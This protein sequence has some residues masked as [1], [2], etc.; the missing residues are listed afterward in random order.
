MFLPLALG[1]VITSLGLCLLSISSSIALACAA[2]FPVGFGSAVFAIPTVTIVQSW[3]DDKTRA[4]ATGFAM[5]G[6]GLGN[7][8]FAFVLQRLID[9]QGWRSAL[10]YEAALTLVVTTFGS[11]LVYR[12]TA[13]GAAA[14]AE[15]TAASAEG[16]STASRATLVNSMSFSEVTR[17]NPFRSVVAFKFIF[18]L[19]YLVF[20]VHI[21]SY[22]QGKNFSSKFAALALAMIGGASILGRISLGYL[23]D[24]I[25]IV[26]NL[27]ISV[28]VLIVCVLLW[29]HMSSSTAILF[30]C[31]AYGFFAGAF[32]SLPPSILAEYYGEVAPQAMFQIVGS[33]FVVEAFGATVGPPFAGFLFD[34]FGDYIVASLTTAFFMTV[35]TLVLSRIETKE[36]F[37]RKYSPPDA[38]L[39]EI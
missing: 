28:T 20:F 10:R 14:S 33:C 21:F 34:Q 6:S 30:L 37:A 22:V 2:A 31:S 36:E 19:G 4:T 26:R 23:A 13:E 3:F 25:G 8:V 35:A 11:A 27:K 39:Y 38:R 24:R 32:P 16:T 12:R 9:D 7:F 17:T 29:P 15:G 5:A 1:G 18:A